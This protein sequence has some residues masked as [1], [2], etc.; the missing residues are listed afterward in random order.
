MNLV[1][2]LYIVMYY[3]ANGGKKLTPELLKIADEITNSSFAIQIPYLGDVL[4]ALHRQKDIDYGALS[5]ALAQFVQEYKASPSAKTSFASVVTQFA[6]WFKSGSPGAYKVLVR[7]S[8]LLESP[9]VRNLIETE[10]IDQ[11]AVRK[12][13]TETTRSLGFAGKTL[14]TVD[15]GKAAKEADPDKYKE[16]LALRRKHSQA[17]KNTVSELVRGSGKKTL[18]FKDV[19]K[20]LDAK[21]F[22]HSMPTGFTGRIDADANWY[23]NDEKLITGVPAAALFPRVVMNTSGSGDWIFV[24]IREDGTQGN[25][26]Y[27]KEQKNKNDSDK[28]AFTSDFIKKLPSYRKKWLVNIRQPFDYTSVNALASVVIELLYLSSQ[29]VGTTAGGNASGAGFG[30]SSILTKMVTVRPNGSVLISYAGKDGIPFK[31]T[32]L[33]GTAVDKTITT[34]LAKLTKGKKPRDPV[35]TRPTKNGT[36]WVPL[37]AGAVTKYFKS[38]T[39]GANIHKLRTAA[40]TGLFKDIIEGYYSAYEGKTLKPALVQ[41]LVKKAAL[42][43][44]KKLG[45]YTRDAST[46]SLSLSPGTS[47]KNYIDPTLQVEFFQH[48]GVP[49]PPY[50]EK[51]LSIENT[52]TSSKRK[53]ESV[54]EAAP[55]PPSPTPKDV[56]LTPRLNNI[57]DDKLS[58]LPGAET[59]PDK[60]LTRLLEQFLQGEAQFHSGGA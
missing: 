2:F 43:V 14:L 13:L 41:D 57:P 54:G 36:S 44:A 59:A 3:Y 34:V 47:L 52:L 37:G 15:E 4:V 29:R 26:F 53:V 40:G 38:I 55:V 5:Y 60:E 45:H 7:T 28:F 9:V 11:T 10:E 33:P 31:F 32:L 12:E 27:S 51:L 42:Q 16:Y 49:I 48:F 18:P 23:T 58:P 17:W 25:Y 56:V 22:E 39:G 6:R 8:S 30:M 46:G 24:A 20:A 50:L 21:G 35:F 1:Q 19:V